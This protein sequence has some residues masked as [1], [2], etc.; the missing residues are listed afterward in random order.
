VSDIILARQKLRGIASELR[1]GGQHEVADEIEDIVEVLMLRRKAV[2]RAPVHSV[3]VTPQVKKQIE[4]LANTTNLHSSEIA[5]KVGVNPG[6]V[7]EVL[8]DDR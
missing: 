3:P 2:R 6:R 5:A 1:E 7:S 4:H 8:Q